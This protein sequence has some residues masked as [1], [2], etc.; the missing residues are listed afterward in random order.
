[1]RKGSGESGWYL[2]WRK[3][4]RHYQTAPLFEWECSLFSDVLLHGH[5]IALSLSIIFT[6]AV[7]AFLGYVPILWIWLFLAAFLIEVVV[8]PAICAQYA[9]LPR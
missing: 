6:I 5:W 2:H 9:S 1:M 3:R 7:Y 4:F 8:E